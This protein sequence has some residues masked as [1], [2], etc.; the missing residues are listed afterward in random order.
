MHDQG[1][2]RQFEKLISNSSFDGEGSLNLGD[3]FLV[4]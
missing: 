2:L 4:K 3:D 1:P